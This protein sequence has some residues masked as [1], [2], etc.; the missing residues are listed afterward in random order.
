M[1]KLLKTFIQGIARV[2]MA[3]RAGAYQQQSTITLL[4]CLATVI[5][6]RDVINQPF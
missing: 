1:Q 3:Q 5:K 2:E 6:S 4:S